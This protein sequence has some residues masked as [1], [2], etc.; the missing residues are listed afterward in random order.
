MPY[1]LVPVR[2]LEHAPEYELSEAALARVHKRR[3]HLRVPLYEFV[4]QTVELL[5][6]HGDL[7]ARD[8]RGKEARR[9]LRLLL[10]LPDGQIDRRMDG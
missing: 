6:A 5:L 8:E 10:C 1:G 7:H 2:G 4:S 9:R 3:D